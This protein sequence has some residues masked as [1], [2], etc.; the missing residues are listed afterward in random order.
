MRNIGRAAL[1]VL[2]CAGFTTGAS[3]YTLKTIH[4]FCAEAD[5]TDG[6]FPSGPLVMDRQGNLF[7][8]T[9]EG[10]NGPRAGTAFELTPGTGGWTHSVIYRFCHACGTRP[11]GGLVLDVSGN[12]YGVAMNGGQ[13]DGGT[14]F[15]LSPPTSGVE[16]SFHRLHSFC[17]KNVCADG[18]LPLA[19]LTYA[20]AASGALYDGVSPLY[21]TTELG[22]DG[23]I[24]V[25]F[26]L[27]QV[28]GKF[29]ESVIHAFNWGSGHTDGAYPVAPATVDGSG[30][31]YGT[32]ETGG[33]FYDPNNGHGGTVF[34]LTP[35][36]D[37]TWTESLLYSFNALPNA[38]DGDLPMAPVLMDSMG[39]LFGAAQFG[40]TNGQ[41]GVAFKL[42]PASPTWQ[43]TVLNN[44]CTQPNCTDGR[45]PN[46]GL[47][48]NGS[49]ALIGTTFLGGI[50]TDHEDDGGGLIYQLSDGN[51]QIVYDFCSRKHCADGADPNGPLIMDS[52]GNLFGTTVSGGRHKAGGGTGTVFEL[53][54]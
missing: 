9:D 33:A 14:V 4:T 41:G 20:G 22:G 38:A 12:L 26:Q 27:A 16:W 17:G 24:G 29:R 43:E 47:M 1:V 21:G 51:F 25:V 50:T 45:F 15:E 54:P 49:G 46:T 23:G 37:G 48:M 30:N 7:G 39:N 13:N 11:I 3:A 35:G 36:P 5:C 18:F 28:R 10:G 8:L 53:I 19:G 2:G 44:F 42:T 6:R 32:T 31:L 40:G 52:A 34:E